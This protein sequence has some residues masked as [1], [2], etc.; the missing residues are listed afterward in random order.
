MEKDA[1]SC[2]KKLSALLRGTTS[3]HRSDFNC[4]SCFH[5]FAT[6]NKWEFH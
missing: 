3:K 1:L 5:S 2:S 4:L 6:E